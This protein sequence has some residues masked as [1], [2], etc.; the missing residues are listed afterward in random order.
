[1]DGDRIDLVTFLLDQT[2]IPHFKAYLTK[3]N[4]PVAIYCLEFLTEVEAT[5]DTSKT[6]LQREGACIQLVLKYLTSGQKASILTCLSASSK[7]IAAKLQNY[8]PGSG[9]GDMFNDIQTDL[10]DNYLSDIFEQFKKEPDFA[11]YKKPF[12]INKQL[13]LHLKVHE[14]VKNATGLRMFREF[15][16]KKY[17]EEN[18]DY[19]VAVDKCM[20]ATSPAEKK[21]LADEIYETFIGPKATKPLGL[22]PQWEE[23]VRSWNHSMLE[24]LQKDVLILLSRTMWPLYTKEHEEYSKYLSNQIFGLPEETV[25]ERVFLIFYPTP[26]GLEKKTIPNSATSTVRQVLTVQCENRGIK[27]NSLVVKDKHGKEVNLDLPLCMV[28]DRIVVLGERK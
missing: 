11:D 6:R 14:H 22:A 28:P 1:M 7:A 17:C 23:D 5:K 25:P 21:A 27:L 8:E 24:P 20:A 16:T 3:T 13:D 18:V 12:R 10:V 2:G 19:I 26:E 15:L 4:Q 9:S